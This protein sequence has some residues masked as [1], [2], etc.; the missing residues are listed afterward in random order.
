VLSTNPPYP[1]AHENPTKSTN[2]FLHEMAIRRDRRP[3]RSPHH[4][5]ILV[6]LST[7]ASDLMIVHLVIG[8]RFAQVVNV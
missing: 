6:D 8:A 3:K 1:L 7:C 2:S 4:S 5:L